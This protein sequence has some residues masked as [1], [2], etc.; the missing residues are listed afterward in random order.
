M[1]GGASTG[2]TVAR[3]GSEPEAPN[4]KAEKRPRRTVKPKER[5]LNLNSEKKLS[6]LVVR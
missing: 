3:N 6:V 2:E 4:T 5:A 1:L